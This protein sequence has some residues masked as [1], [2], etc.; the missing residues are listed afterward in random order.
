MSIFQVVDILRWERLCKPLSLFCLGSTFFFLG[1]LSFCSVYFNLLN[2]RSERLRFGTGFSGDR[3][4]SAQNFSSR[5]VTSVLLGTKAG[6]RLNGTISGELQL[7]GLTVPHEIHII[8][9]VSSHTNF[10]MA[11]AFTFARRTF[12][13]FRGLQEKNPSFE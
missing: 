8:I 7:H 5:Q 1:C 13:V 10:E 11:I 12:E 3:H 9:I 2:K 4:L 6:G